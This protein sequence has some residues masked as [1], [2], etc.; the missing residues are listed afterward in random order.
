[1][2]YF[3]PAAWRAFTYAARALMN[4]SLYLP[5]SGWVPAIACLNGAWSITVSFTPSVATCAYEWRRSWPAL[6]GH[7]CDRDHT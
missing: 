2:R 1:M 7:L 3:L 5:R 4:F 6:E